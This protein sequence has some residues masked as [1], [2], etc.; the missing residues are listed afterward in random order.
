MRLIWRVKYWVVQDAI[1]SHRQIFIF[2]TIPCDSFF[3]LRFAKYELI[4]NKRSEGKLSGNIPYP[5]VEWILFFL[6]HVTPVCV[7]VISAIWDTQKSSSW[8]YPLSVGRIYFKLT[9][10]IL[11]WICFYFDVYVSTQIYPS[12]F[13]VVCCGK[14][15]KMLKPFGVLLNTLIFVCFYYHS[16]NF[17][18]V[19]F[20]FFLWW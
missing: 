13:K 11:I 12:Y 4:C 2:C 18:F 6:I 10:A 14:F 1:Y 17:V 16:D 7:Y 5:F 20:C 8:R 3:L 15:N 19:I 9:V